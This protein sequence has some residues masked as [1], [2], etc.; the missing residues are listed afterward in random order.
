MITTAA[1]WRLIAGRLETTPL[2]DTLA[3]HI[4]E[5]LG[6]QGAGAA[7]TIPLDDNQRQL[8]KA[9]NARIPRNQFR[10]VNRYSRVA[11]R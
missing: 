4:A 7:V 2:G 5:H 11:P 1:H 9:T 3:G 8:V 10:A 6:R